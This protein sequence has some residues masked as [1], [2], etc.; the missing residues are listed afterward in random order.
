[1]VYHCDDIGGRFLYVVLS[2]LTY[3]FL[4]AEQKTNL[5]VLWYV[6]GVGLQ[7]LFRYGS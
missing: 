6:K 5:C 7:G 4:L 2:E 1:M 3:G